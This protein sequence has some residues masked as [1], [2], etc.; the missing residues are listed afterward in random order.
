M[1]YVDTSRPPEQAARKAA[2]FNATLMQ[3]NDHHLCPGCGEPVAI[4][5]VAEVI[6]EME[7]AQKTISVFGH[8]CY[9]PFV[10]ALD[11]ETT[12]CLHGRGPAVA[13]GM[14]RM[15]PD[16]LI[17]TMQG[18]GDMVSEGLAEVL[19]TAARGENITCIMLNN[20]VFGDTGGQM[21]AATVV[22]QRTK[23]TLEGRDARYHGMPITIGDLVAQLDGSAY[24]ARGS[25]HSNAAIAQTK[26]MVRRAFERQ[27][28]GA[29]FGLVEIL[30]MC[31][32]GWLIPT[33]GGPEYLIETL[34][35]AYPL[36]EIKD[37]GEGAPITI[38]G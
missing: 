30:T 21:T 5:M 28:E 23:N 2:S 16:C 6:A 36:R 35:E 22:G 14:K 32:T 37:V 29:G 20:G 12:L 11:V 15:R 3:T 18:D 34:G 10:A 38:K 4:R 24:I 31:P 1:N 9:G 7:L 19:H 13:T 26:K 27:M 8:G 33:P 17:W 25:V